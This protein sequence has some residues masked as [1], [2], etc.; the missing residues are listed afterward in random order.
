MAI[1]L[2]R[3]RWDIIQLIYLNWLRGNTSSF[4]LYLDTKCH[5]IVLSLFLVTKEDVFI[6]FSKKNIWEPEWLWM[7][8]MTNHK[9]KGHSAETLNEYQMTNLCKY[10]CVHVICMSVVMRVCRCVCRDMRVH[11]RVHLRKNSITV[12]WC[13]CVRL[14]Y[15]THN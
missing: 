11:A 4:F 8:A 7:K 13:G 3:S 14:N 9:P 15:P 2:I 1:G 5:I 12:N 10:I 6:S